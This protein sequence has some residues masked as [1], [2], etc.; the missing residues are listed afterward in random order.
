MLPFRGASVTLLCEDDSMLSLRGSIAALELTFMA[1]FTSE[2]TANCVMMVLMQ[3]L[4]A[5][6]GVTRPWLGCK[7]MLGL[8]FLLGVAG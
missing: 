6:C 7:F 2:L 8:E 5:I 4:R 3:D 1:K